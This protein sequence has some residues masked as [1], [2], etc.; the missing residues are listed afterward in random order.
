MKH[1]YIYILG[2]ICLTMMTSCLE[3]TSVFEPSGPGDEVQFSLGISKNAQTKT[4]K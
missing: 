3:E 4:R 1:N 2:I